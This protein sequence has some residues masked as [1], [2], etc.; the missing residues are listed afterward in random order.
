MG[1][2]LPFKRAPT[3]E[4]KFA[5]ALVSIIKHVLEG[6]PLPEGVVLLNLDTE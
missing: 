4:E 3:E 5:E 6:E 2:V 1:V